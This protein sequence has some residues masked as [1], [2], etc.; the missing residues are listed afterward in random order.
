MPP[1]A[2]SLGR[3]ATGPQRHA[4]YRRQR[5]GPFLHLGPVL[6]YGVGDRTVG[7]HSARR[8]QARRPDAR[9]SEPA[10]QGA[11]ARPWHGFSPD[12]KT[13]AVIS[14]GSNSVTFIDT[15]AN[16]VKHTSYVGRSPH[17]AFFRPD[18]RE[19]WVAMR[20]ENYI[21]VLDGKTF[22]PTTR[23]AV[24]NGPGMTIF[25]P[26][27]KYGTSARASPPRRSSSTPPARRSWA[28]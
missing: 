20:G 9:Q 11:V 18:G 12:R 15:A 4:R 8:H 1:R 28:A 5:A 22:E 17:E 19:V 10:L 13:L 23:I 7:Q 25:S 2:G 6:Q 26:N 3:R 27:G 21:Q 16:A 14:I 24:P